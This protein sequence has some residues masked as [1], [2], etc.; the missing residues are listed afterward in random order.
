MLGIVLAI[1]V[2]AVVAILQSAVL[3]RMPLLS[4]TADLMLLAVA[5]WV[6]HERVRA[7][8]WW[9]L[10]GGVLSGY[11][12]ALP[13]FVFPAAYVLVTG[14]AL[15]IRRRVWKAPILAMLATVFF[16]TLIVHA[17]SLLA[18]SLRGTLLPFGD[19]I[20]L[21]TLPSLLLN[22]LLALPVYVV[23]RDLANW[24]YPEEIGY[25]E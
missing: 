13:I 16:G 6:L 17:V 8:W 3:S 14:F 5:G 18:V 25:D 11:L 2:L 15:L 21:I 19:V 4:G 1:P 24:I 23:M 12:S 20:N 7:H 22:L 10:A 9:A